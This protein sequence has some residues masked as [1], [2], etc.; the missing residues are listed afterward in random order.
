MGGGLLLLFTA[1][2]FGSGCLNYNHPM[3]D[4]FIKKGQQKRGKEYGTDGYSDTAAREHSGERD[5]A[6]GA[7]AAGGG[8]AADDLQIHEEGYFPCAD[9]F[10]KLCKALDVSSDFIL[11]L[12]AY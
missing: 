1:D 3:Y 2:L 7:C 8:I 12:K 10:A 5:C 4:I 6:K 9:T 11:G